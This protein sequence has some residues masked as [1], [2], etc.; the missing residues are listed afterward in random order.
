MLPFLGAWTRTAPVKR[1]GSQR[2]RHSL[3]RLLVILFPSLPLLLQNSLGCLPS[4]DRLGTCAP[5]SSGDSQPAPEH[6]GWGVPGLHGALV[7]HSLS[8]S[9][10]PV[11]A[12]SRVSLTERQPGTLWENRG[13]LP[14]TVLGAEWSPAALGSSWQL[15]LGL[16]HGR[17]VSACWVGLEPLREGWAM[18]HRAGRAEDGVQAWG[19][20]SWA[21]RAAVGTLGRKDSGPE[22]GSQ[23][24]GRQPCQEGSS[25]AQGLLSCVPTPP[26]PVPQVPPGVG[27]DRACPP[28]R[29]P[30]GTCAQALPRAPWEAVSVPGTESGSK[31]V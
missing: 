12:L 3:G 31:L 16:P 26:H 28:S 4:G 14:C 20:L 21:L 17:R 1:W 22:C 10:V 23:S 30:S 2:V 7:G 13:A 11:R 19:A 8:V 24:L 5:R 29:H 18:G 27:P 9:S 15:V 6:S 25:L